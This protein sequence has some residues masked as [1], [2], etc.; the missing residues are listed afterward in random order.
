[1]DVFHLLLRFQGAAVRR[2]ITL[3]AA[4]WLTTEMNVLESGFAT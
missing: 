3:V 1:M 2:A 4:T